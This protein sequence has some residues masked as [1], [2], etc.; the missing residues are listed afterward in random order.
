MVNKFLQKRAMLLY[1]LW[2]RHMELYSD[3]RYRMEVTSPR[4]VC[5]WAKFDPKYCTM[6]YRENLNKTH[7]NPFF[8]FNESAEVSTDYIKQLAEGTKL[9]AKLDSIKDTVGAEFNTRRKLLSIARPKNLRHAP[10][11]HEFDLNIIR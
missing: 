4:D 8:R 2:N 3:L 9:R 7:P 5:F 6:S 1:W 10:L 11:D